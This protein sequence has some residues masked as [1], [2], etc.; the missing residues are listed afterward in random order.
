[1]WSAARVVSTAADAAE[2]GPPIERTRIYV[3]DE[4]LRPVPVGVVGE[5]CLAGHG[6]ARGYHDR[7]RLT[8]RSFRPDPW[9]DEPGARM[10]R[11]GDL[12]RWRE[13]GGLEL[14]GR[15]DHQVKVRGYR[16]ECGEIEVVLRAHRDV[17]QAVVVAAARA[18]E[19][20]LVAYIVPRRG[21]SLA[22][23]QTVLL[24]ELRPHLRASLPDYMIP[25][26]VIALSSLPLTPNA[27]V[28]RA[29]LPAPQWGAQGS[30]VERVEPRNPVEAALARIWSDLLATESPIGVHD[31]LF[32]LGAHSLTVT[33]FVVRVADAYDVNL[34]VHHVFAGPTIAELAEVIS[35]DPNFGADTASPRH[36]ELDAL[37]DEDLDELLRAAL[38]QRNR[39]QAQPGGGDS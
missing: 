28:D 21:S 16:I 1:M 6:V 14:I 22:R 4:H 13:G 33:R 32:A 35:A 23:P 26:L 8:A 36:P 15:N 10:Y 27:K 12:G 20:E 3:L 19:P 38:A 11:T 17:R 31:N 18:G 29:A 5:V 39:R 7:P 30:A 37:S 25:S 2:I 9:S 24:D 34:P